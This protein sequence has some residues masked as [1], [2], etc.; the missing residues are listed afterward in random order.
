MLTGLLHAVGDQIYNVKVTPEVLEINKLKT[1][2]IKEHV[3]FLLHIHEEEM[4]SWKQQEVTSSEEVTNLSNTSVKH[5]RKVS[6]YFKT[7]SDSVKNRKV[8]ILSAHMLIDVETF[9]DI[10]PYHVLFNSSLQILQAGYKLQILSGKHFIGIPYD[11][12]IFQL[13]LINNYPRLTR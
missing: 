12:F 6:K 8:S 5:D 13:Q 1:G 7:G 9:C 3:I 11:I 10:F 4:K 2:L